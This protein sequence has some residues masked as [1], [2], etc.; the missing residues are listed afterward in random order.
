MASKKLSDLQAKL[1]YNARKNG[2]VIKRNRN[3]KDRSVKYLIPFD[4]EG[5]LLYKAI[6]QYSFDAY[7]RMRLNMKSIIWKEKFTF[8]DTIRIEKLVRGR[9][10]AYFTCVSVK[11]MLQYTLFLN[12]LVSVLHEGNIVN[13]C[14]TG[15]WEFIKR[16]EYFGILFAGEGQ[17]S[18]LV[19]NIGINVNEST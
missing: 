19:D 16:G 18:K 1:R 4:S 17:K 15:E 2:K 13:G 3:K 10:S 5:N 14:I 12:D 8:T 6:P 11:S 7:G 9:A